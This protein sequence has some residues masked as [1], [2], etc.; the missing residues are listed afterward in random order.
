[1]DT[2]KLAE[3]AGYTP[4][5]KHSPGILLHTRPTSAV[6]GRVVE[7]P[8]T[9]FKQFP[10]GRIVGNDGYYAPDIPAHQGILKGP[11]GM[12]GEIRTMHGERILGKIKEKLPAASEATY[13]HLTLGYRPMPQDRLPIVG[14]S[15]GNS[16]VYIAVM[17]SGVTLAAIMGRY[18]SHELMNNELIDELAPYRPDRF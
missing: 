9:Y 8:T 13:D 3:Q 7:S 2:P 14:F 5:L 6:L 17:H 12:P 11:L 4:P 18:I 15:P 10:D 1:V 16:D